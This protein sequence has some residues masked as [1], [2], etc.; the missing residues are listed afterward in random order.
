MGGERERERERENE[1]EYFLR[2][3]LLIRGQER[4]RYQASFWRDCGTQD[5]IAE[6]VDE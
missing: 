4:R 6:S 5:S 3:R 1:R 2:Q